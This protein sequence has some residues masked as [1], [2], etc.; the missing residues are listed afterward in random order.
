MFNYKPTWHPAQS[1]I[2]QHPLLTNYL[3]VQSWEELATWH[4]R[5]KQKVGSV[6][7][8][9]LVRVGGNLYTAIGNSRQH[10]SLIII[11]I[12]PLIILKV[13]CCDLGTSSGASLRSLASI[14]A[15]SGSSSSNNTRVASKIYLKSF[16]TVISSS[17]IHSRVYR[18]VRTW[19]ALPN[20]KYIKEALNSPVLTSITTLLWKPSPDTT[21]TLF[22]ST[23]SCFTM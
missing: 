17:N 15:H 21:C 3:I 16:Q 11:I 8:A 9:Q 4:L 20:T 12:I 5:E 14:T 10:N 13:H 22:L 2:H 7:H 1:A 18:V 19:V 6:L 23:T